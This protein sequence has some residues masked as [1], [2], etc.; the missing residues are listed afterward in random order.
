[1]LRVLVAE[2][3]PVVRE[4]LVRLLGRDSELEV[5][6]VAGDGAQAVARALELAPDVI[7][8]DVHMPRMD[9]LAATR[10][11][12]RTLPTPIVMMTAA[13][14]EEEA[15]MTFEAIQ[16]GA[17]T[18][19]D[20]PS[21]H[22]GDAR[23]RHLVQTVKSMAEVKV[24][25]RWARREVSRPPVVP[26]AP[27]PQ[28]RLV[29]MGAS[30]GGPP[31][32]RAILEELR[33]DL[34]VPLLLVQHITPGFASSLAGWLGEGTS[35][36]VKLAQAGEELRAGTGYLA[37]DGADMAVDRSGRIRLDPPPPHHHHCPSVDGMFLSVAEAYGP[38][39]VGVI[40]TGM[41]ADGAAGLGRLRAAGG[42][43]IAQD[44]ST[45]AVFGMP[46]AAIR[47]GAAARVLALDD[48]AGAINAMVTRNP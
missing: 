32:L 4:L 41:G 33:P 36:K 11:L 37:P 30:T 47:R 2:D 44:E 15:R 48:I 29:A 20:K 43:T 17:L 35:V 34:G 31:A 40:L 7:L 16:A 8:M 9:G 10:E 25:R 46:R 19:A 13:S 3:S 39:A 18:L 28:L 5:V 27:L 22:D 42:V 14:G 38:R 12:M 45:S 6:G 1:M 21:V 23:A 26:P 24:V